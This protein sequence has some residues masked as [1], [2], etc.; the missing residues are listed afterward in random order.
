MGLTFSSTGK[1]LASD[2]DNSCGGLKRSLSDS[3]TDIGRAYA[4]AV[5]ILED[6]GIDT[7]ALRDMSVTRIVLTAEQIAEQAVTREIPDYYERDR[8]IDAVL[9]HRI[10]GL[11]VMLLMLMVIFYITIAGA[12]YP[13]Q[14]LSEAFGSLGEVLRNGLISLSAPK[15]LESVLIDGIYCVLTWVTF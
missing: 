12:N 8:R 9:T 2:N 3:D 14:W 11:P 10:W 1:S 5:R 4:E 7:A 6:D 15:W 13:S